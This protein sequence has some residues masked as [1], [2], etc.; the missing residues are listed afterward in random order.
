MKTDRNLLNISW[1][2][3]YGEQTLTI[4]DGLFSEE[5]FFI[6]D[7][8]QNIIFWSQGAEALL[9]FTKEEAVGAHCLKTN[10]ATQCI[11][12]CSVKLHSV[13]NG[14]Q[15]ELYNQAGEIIH[16]KKYASALYARDGSFAGTIERL[17]PAQETSH[18]AY[19]P[20]CEELHG[21]LSCSPKMKRLFTQIK[22]VAKT[23]VPVLARGES[24]AGK[25]LL[26]R[27]I[28]LESARAK[29]PFIAVNCSAI[30]QNLIESELFGHKKGAFTG[31]YQD[32]KGLF[33]QA[34]GGSLFLDEIAELPLSIQAKLLR[35]LETQEFQPVGS[36]TNIKVDVRIIAAT[37]KSLRSEVSKGTFR[38]DLMYRLRV[39]PLFIPPLRERKEDIEILLWHFIQKAQEKG[40]RTIKTIST[41]TL[42][43]LKNHSWQGNIRELR[44]IVEYALVI[45]AGDSIQAQDLP[46]EFQEARLPFESEQKSKAEIPS[47]VETAKTFYTEEERIRE[48]LRLS[49]GHLGKAAEFLRMSRPTLW[50]KRKKYEL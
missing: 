25:E 23:E 26:A 3:K 40:A 32:R 14:A 47:S 17:K 34:N 50:R 4:F 42:N 5:A 9:G 27:A 38:Q 33:A 15:V 22:S 37:H 41:A 39:V 16:A 13:V 48:A 11:S 49:S 19:Q 21:M 45:G 7:A 24:G 20:E 30:P 8:T 28:H 43:L 1:L 46:P 6:T 29:K 35:V 12:T 31:A 18:E 44:N 36:E 10:R 2:R